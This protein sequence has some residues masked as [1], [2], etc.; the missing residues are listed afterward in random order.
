[1]TRR[2]LLTGGPGFGKS[3]IIQELEKMEYAVFHEIARE[4]IHHEMQTGGDAVPWLN[5]QSFS[6]QVLH[7]RIRQHAEGT[8]RLSFYDRGLPDIAA[9]L[10]KEKQ[11]VPDEI[12]ALCRDLNYDNPVFI[13][14]PWENIFHR[15]EERKE[16]FS[17]AIRV[18][19][20]IEQILS[21][22]GYELVPVP[23]GSIRWRAEFVLKHLGM[24]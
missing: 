7:G 22:L 16:D 23:M 17:A 10:M 19:K 12:N 3:S 14:P 18:H 4:I 21:E 1:V 13:T 9:F 5:I 15:D 8:G 6:E 24:M 2:I 11:I 20:A